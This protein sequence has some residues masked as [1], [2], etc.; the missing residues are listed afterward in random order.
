MCH[1]TERLPSALLWNRVAEGL[2]TR[3]IT[4]TVTIPL[5][6]RMLPQ[7]EIVETS[8]RGYAFH[9]IMV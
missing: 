6:K 2:Q 3:T 9:A 8:F 5:R 4:P 1:K 7:A